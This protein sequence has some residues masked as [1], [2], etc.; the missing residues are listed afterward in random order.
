MIELELLNPSYI[1]V[2][3]NDNW[4]Q[5][6]PLKFHHTCL[7]LFIKFLNILETDE[8]DHADD[9]ATNSS[10]AEL[11]QWNLKTIMKRSY[12]YRDLAEMGSKLIS[13]TESLIDVVRSMSPVVDTPLLTNKFMAIDME[14]RGLCRE[15]SERLQNFSDRL[16]HDLKYLE[17]ARNMNQN[18]GVQQ[19]TLLATIFLPLSLAAGVL[20]MQTRFKD[21]GTLLYDFF[22]VVVLLAAI[23]LI[24]MI[25]LSLVAAV[26]ELDSKSLRNESY[27]ESLRGKFLVVVNVGFFVFGCLVLS[28]FL[29]GMFSDVTLGAKILGYGVA[30]ICG[31]WTVALL[32]VLGGIVTLGLCL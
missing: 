23:V 26:K 25:L 1:T 2:R 16:D 18:R 13:T 14:L 4:K 6:F 22:G 15:A 20:S 11:R 7:K 31:L 28:S 19:L 30:A 12:E 8:I 10:K 3:S 5:I 29:V 24:I 27:R 9:A 17:L 21:L 32:L